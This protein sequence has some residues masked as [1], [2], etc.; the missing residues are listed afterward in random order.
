MDGIR[1]INI[2]VFKYLSLSPKGVASNFRV[3]PVQRYRQGFVHSYQFD[4]RFGDS[5]NFFVEKGRRWNPKVG[6]VILVT[7]QEFFDYPI[8]LEKIAKKGV[9]IVSFIHD[10]F[11]IIH[12][13]WFPPDVKKIFLTRVQRQIKHSF[14]IISLSQKNVLD[15]MENSDLL[16]TRS[17]VMPLRFTISTL[18]FMNNSLKQRS[19]EISSRRNLLEISKSQGILKENRIRFLVLGTLEPRKGLSDLVEVL[20][21]MDDERASAIEITLIGRIGWIDRDLL[22]RIK[23]L[24]V[25]MDSFYLFTNASD[26]LINEHLSQTDYLLM[27]SF[28]EGFGLPILEAEFLNVPVILRNIPI[29]HEVSKKPCIFFDNE[30]VTLQ[31][32]KFILESNRDQ[33]EHMQMSIRNQRPIERIVPKELIDIIIQSLERSVRE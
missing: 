8:V 4:E 5:K 12:P 6:D 23:K 10:V 7:A 28:D 20:E 29:F 9:K 33:L 26:E 27:T 19:I 15:L 14:E 24:S 30:G 17:E 31:S 13:E 32:L 3:I 25:L 18:S 2:E 1:R 11:P 22:K 16:K 21:V